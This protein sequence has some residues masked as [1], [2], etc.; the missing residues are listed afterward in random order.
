MMLV[1]NMYR[2]RNKSAAHDQE[3]ERAFWISQVVD[4]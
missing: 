2:L 3:V 1:R 4:D